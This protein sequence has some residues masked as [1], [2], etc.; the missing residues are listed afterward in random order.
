ME[1]L[2]NVKVHIFS[3]IKVIEMTLFNTQTTKPLRLEEFEQSQV[4]AATTISLYLEDPWI[5][6]TR[7]GVRSALQYMGKGWF[8]LDEQNYATYAQS[9]MFKML[10]V[11]RFNM[12][13]AL[14]YLVEGSC[15]SY[16]EMLEETCEPCLS[17]AQDFAWGKDLKNSKFVSPRAPIL[18]MELV[19]GEEK[20]AYKTEIDA[21]ERIMVNIFDVAIAKT[22]NVPQIERGVVDKIFWKG[23]ALL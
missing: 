5:N 9:K 7:G 1:A 13:D 14:R 12:Q 6:Q 8:N 15:R 18:L 17:I 11:M 3:S 22:Q 20:A 2:V 4:S 19:L 10:N 16:L 23:N 21:I